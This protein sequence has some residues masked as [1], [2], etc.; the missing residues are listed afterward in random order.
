MLHVTP[1]THSL[2]VVENVITETKDIVREAQ[3]AWL[4]DVMARTGMTQTAIAKRIGRDAS[5]LSKF[6]SPNARAGH[7]LSSDIIAA[8][9]RVTGIA[10]VDQPAVPMAPRGFNEPDATPFQPEAHRHSDVVSSVMSMA[11]QS[12]TVDAWTMQSRA[13]ET[14]GIMPGDILMVDLNATPRA[15]DTV[16]AQIYDWPQNQARIVFR[17]YESPFLVAATTDRA[18]MRPELVDQEKVVIRGVVVATVRPRQAA[19]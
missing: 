6:L 9:S 11:T 8:I 18:L 3:L 13:L 16:C 15:G 1:P 10:A 17:L 7:T 12:N 2:R 4:R 5:T 14:V 19:A